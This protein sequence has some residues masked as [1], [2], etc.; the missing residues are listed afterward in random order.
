MA[1]I[2]ST[3][4][5]LLLSVILVACGGG[6]SD[7]P[8]TEAP[9]TCTPIAQVRVQL[10][11]DSTM[12]GYTAE[13][14]AAAQHAPVV[15]LQQILDA[16]FGAGATLVTVRAMGG[17]TS[18]ELLN[19]TDTVN[20]AWPKSVDA[21]IV[22]I[23]HGINDLTHVGNV[24]TYR[25]NL[26]ALAANTAGA[27]LVLET[28]NVVA[29]HDLS[30]Y[31][32]AMRDVAKAAGAPVAD[33]FA[34]TSALPDW[35]ARLSDWAHPRDAFYQQIVTTSLAPAVVPVVAAMLCR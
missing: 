34:F 3:L 30:P 32:Q 13:T 7:A 24:A 35:H 19:G 4:P 12:V 26:Q 16:R 5:A 14:D 11:G 2:K 23:N 31:A 27:K 1:S 10:F 29:E 17:T 22:V 33:T 9:S 21:D 20:Q 18:G 6:G 28:P 15:M 25:A 8:P